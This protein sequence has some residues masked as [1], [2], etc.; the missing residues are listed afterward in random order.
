MLFESP[1]ACFIRHIK[2]KIKNIKL[3]STTT[4]AHTKYIIKSKPLLGLVF[5]CVKVYIFPHRGHFHGKENS[6][7]PLF[8]VFSLYFSMSYSLNTHCH[9]S[10]LSPEV[11]ALIGRSC[12]LKGCTNQRLHSSSA[13]VHPHYWVPLSPRLAP[14]SSPILTRKGFVSSCLFSL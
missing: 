8:T 10:P 14:F 4:S 11:S 1:L 13:N 3:N 12:G 9:L 7:S 5:F 2:Q 6:L